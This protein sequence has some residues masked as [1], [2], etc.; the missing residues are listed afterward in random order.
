PARRDRSG[1]VLPG[2]VLSHP[3]AA[4]GRGGP[5]RRSTGGP[6]G[7]PAGGPGR[8]EAP[9]R[10]G[11]LPDHGPALQGGGRAQA[12][13]LPLRANGR[14]GAHPREGGE[15]RHGSGGQPMSTPE[16]SIPSRIGTL[17]L[18]WLVSHK[19][20]QTPSEIVKG[21]KKTVGNERSK[22]VEDEIAAL[23]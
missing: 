21:L 10:A 19:G 12:G 23:D 3:S 13:A 18:A 7:V 14:L 17:I 8:P 22:A 9:R 16:K 20:T 11:A 2:P 4:R 6:Q 1:A 5:P 15:A